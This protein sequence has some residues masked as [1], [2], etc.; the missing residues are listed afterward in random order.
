MDYNTLNDIDGRIS[1]ESG[2]TPRTATSLMNRI[3]DVIEY[4]N[5]RLERALERIESGGL[6][7]EEANDFAVFAEHQSELSHEILLD[8]YESSGR[9]DLLGKL[10]PIREMN[11]VFFK[12]VKRYRSSEG[13]LTLHVSA[14]LPEHNHGLT[15]RWKFSIFKATIDIRIYYIRERFFIELKLVEADQ[16]NYSYG[17]KDFVARQFFLAVFHHSRDLSALDPPL[18]DR[19]F[20]F[21]L[22]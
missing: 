9:M 16:F 6:T 18:S 4:Q 5:L 12:I 21:W 13:G 15:N 7:E 11:D 8:L 2:S 14:Y 17:M 20:K 3:L 10:L 22:V 1:S 19:T